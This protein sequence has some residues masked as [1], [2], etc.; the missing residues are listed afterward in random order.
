MDF[1]LTEDQEAIKDAI[2]QICTKFDDAYW[3]KKDKE[4]GFPNDFYKAVADGGWRGICTPEEY[5]G[6]GL[7]ITE[8]CIMMQAICQ[9]GAGMSGATT[10]HINLFGL[11]PVVK[12]G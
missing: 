10:V 11:H 8:A 4:G 1:R 3:L 7:G 9:S 12:H 5:G 2:N 6:S